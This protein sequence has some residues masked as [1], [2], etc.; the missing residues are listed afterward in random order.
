MF[1]TIFYL[2]VDDQDIFNPV[3]GVDMFYCVYLPEEF[4]HFGDMIDML[5]LDTDDTSEAYNQIAEEYPIVNEVNQTISGMNLR[6][7]IS[8]NN[9]HGAYLLKSDVELTR[10]DIR[11]IIHSKTKEEL[12]AFLKEAKMD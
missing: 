3:I 11:A 5:T 8:G 9:T 10:D 6:H 7:I 12:T 2:G 4:N 1:Y